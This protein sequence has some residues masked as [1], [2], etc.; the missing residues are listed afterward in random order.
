VNYGS[1][2][3]PVLG[4]VSKAGKASAA[5]KAGTALPAAKTWFGKSAVEFGKKKQLGKDAGWT[6]SSNHSGHR[7]RGLPCFSKHQYVSG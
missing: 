7:G 4:W 6:G 2:A 1:A 5:V 3:I